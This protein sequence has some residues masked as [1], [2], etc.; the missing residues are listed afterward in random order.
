MASAAEYAQWIVQNADKRGTPEFDTVARAYEAA[1]RQETAPAPAAQPAVE[2]QR[3]MGDRIVG[4]LET[5]GT[6]ATGAVATPVAAVGGL[7][8]GIGQ[9]ILSG[10]YDA[11]QASRAVDQYA[12]RIAGAMTMQPQTAAGREYVGAIGRAA[13]AVAPMQGMLPQAAVITQS[14]RNAAPAMQTAAT[15]GAI[16]AGEVAQQAGQR[17][18][19]RAQAVRG[20]LPGGAEAAAAPR[21]M[22]GS[23]GAAG[24][25]AQ[26][27]R[28]AVAESLPV[29]VKLT[30]GEAFRD[31]DQLR[32]E[33]GAMKSEAGAPLRARREESNAAL[34]ANFDT[35]ADMTGARAPDLPATGKAVKDALFEGY[36]A[37]KNKTNVAYN[38]AFSSEEAKIP[39][40][41]DTVVTLP[42]RREGDAPIVKSP[43]Q[44]INDQ[45]P[46]TDPVI[47]K[48]REWALK[49]GIAVEDKNGNLMAR[50]SVPEGQ[51]GQSKPGVTV[52]QMEKW[53]SEISGTAAFDNQ[54]SIRY[55]TILKKL[56][57]GVTEP[58]EGPLFKQARATRVEQAKKFENRA[59]V[60]RLITSR[61]NMD[62]P[63]VAVE[64]VFQ[65][66]VLNG[67]A[68]ELRFL[69]GVL[70]SGG[71]NGAQAWR[72]LQGA[73]ANYIKE[74]ATKN[75]GTDSM[76]R[77]I[78][79]TDGVV[80]AVRA[81]D[82]NG[83]LDIM[84]GKKD[85]Q[86][87]R[88]IAEVAQ[89]LNTQPEGTVLRTGGDAFM[90]MSAVAETGLWST[91]GVPLPVLTGAKMVAAK[92]KDV[93]LRRRID[94]ALN[95]AKAKEKRERV[96]GRSL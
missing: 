57:D 30:T 74:Q 53:R 36:E 18:Q 82:K 58:V 24:V 34:L 20:M 17:V 96:T 40:S 31:P 35:V 81:L 78:V 16:R 5:A 90:M 68:D 28:Q 73:T 70:E 7:V 13:E 72:E 11:Q 77:P 87:M 86:T 9:Q 22:G 54:K 23:V 42:A 84:L 65:R 88:D 38:K 62:D 75:I 2:P 66:T 52:A 14:L 55:E 89:W 61:G 19:Q 49:L 94:D 47:S 3:S 60:Q 48:A 63:L 45:P 32:F 6:M 43:L 67:S 4:A 21:T 93:K 79:S 92:M 64:Q 10:Q 46:G 56:I 95:A 26:S 50:A 29:P 85:A 39:V 80:K 33:L 71:E 1:R 41:P 44:F 15:V 37:A 83:R 69:K 27:M 76:G 8:A 59:I 91:I 12:Q 51:M 25:E